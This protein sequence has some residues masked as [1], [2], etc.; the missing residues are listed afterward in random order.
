[1]DAIT[2]PRQ[3]LSWQT[4][5]KRASVCIAE[6]VVGTDSIAHAA[7]KNV[8][9]INAIVFS[10]GIPV[11]TIRVYITPLC[12][13]FEVSQKRTGDSSILLMATKL[14]TFLNRAKH[15]LINLLIAISF[16]YL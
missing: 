7:K 5:R 15:L 14:V 4:K 11:L 1:M 10:L 12:R 16:L 9:R 6:A 3:T 13:S 8:L 2:V